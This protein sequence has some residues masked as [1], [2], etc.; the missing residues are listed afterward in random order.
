[1]KETKL[2]IIAV[3]LEIITL[4]I[5]VLPYYYGY[6]FILFSLIVTAPLIVVA[7]LGIILAIYG[8]IKTKSTFGV[9]ISMLAIVLPILAGITIWVLATNAAEVMESV[10]VFM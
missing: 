10:V 8:L 7:V 6:I 4:P 2:P 1:M 9:I 3:V 5:I